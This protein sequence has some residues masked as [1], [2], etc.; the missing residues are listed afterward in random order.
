MLSLRGSGGDH[1][2]LLSLKWR[3]SLSLLLTLNL[4]EVAAEAREAATEEGLEK[5]VVK[6]PTANQIREAEK[7][8][9][10]EG[11]QLGNARDCDGWGDTTATAKNDRLW[12]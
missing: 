10:N 9:S 4:W 7:C 3:L 12:S 2:L 1:P 8:A 5:T 11:R 6:K